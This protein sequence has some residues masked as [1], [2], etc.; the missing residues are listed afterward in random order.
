MNEAQLILVL[1]K[2]EEKLMSLLTKEEYMEFAKSVARET[3]RA[4]IEGMKDG[5]FKTFCLENFGEITK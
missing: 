5:D 4:E 3:F 1:K 2:Y